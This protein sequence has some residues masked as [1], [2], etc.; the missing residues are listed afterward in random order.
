MK[1]LLKILTPII[2]LFCISCD[3]LKLEYKLDNSCSFPCWKGLTLGMSYEEALKIVNQWEDYSA[4]EKKG[5]VSGRSRIVLKNRSGELNV[6]RFSSDHSLEIISLGYDPLRMKLPLEKVI[7]ALGEPD[8]V[9]VWFA[10]RP[11]NDI[12]A[13][14]CYPDTGITVDLSPIKTADPPKGFLYNI[15]HESNVLSIL[16]DIIDP[17]LSGVGG[18]ECKKPLDIALKHEW[19]GYGNYQSCNPDTNKLCAPYME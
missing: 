14:L 19:I 3:A 13:V 18:N 16:I 1:T 4:E 17:A 11:M 10:G 5:P 7:N 2:L 15:N 8:H 12:K 9:I 6:L